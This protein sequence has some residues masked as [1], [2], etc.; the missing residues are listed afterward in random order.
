MQYGAVSKIENSENLESASSSN[1]ETP[2]REATKNEKT[3]QKITPPTFEKKGIQ[4]AKLWWRR[5]TQYIKM[6][7]NFDLNIMTTDREI[8]EQYRAELEERKKVLF[9][10]ALGESATTEMTRTVR[11][12]D[13]NKMD[14]NQLYSV[15]RLHF[16]S[17][18]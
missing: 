1:G 11:D 10:W 17:R 8:L 13:P 15:F 4:E 3:H 18:T 7:Q 2:E 14:I 5:F 16:Y 6:T 9:K 12:S